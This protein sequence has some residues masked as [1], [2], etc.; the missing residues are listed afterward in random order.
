MTSA[1]IFNSKVINNEGEQN[2]LPLLNP[3]SMCCGILI[4][5]G[6]VE[7]CGKEVVGELDSLEKAVETFENFEIYSAIAGFVGELVL[8][9][10]LIRNIGKADALIF[11]VAERGVQV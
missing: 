6:F 7:A 3:E 4:V 1:N 5:A 11:V 10:K 2:R 8:L 9:E